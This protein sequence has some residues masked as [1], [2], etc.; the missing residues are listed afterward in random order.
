MVVDALSIL[1]DILK[2][3]GVL[4]QT[5]NTSLLFVEPIWMQEVKNYLEAS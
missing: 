3:L 2:P 1:L 4:D 5:I